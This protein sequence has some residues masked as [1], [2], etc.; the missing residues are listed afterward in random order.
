MTIVLASKFWKT[1]VG[2]IFPSTSEKQLEQKNK[3]VTRK[4]NSYIT[5]LVLCFIFQDHVNSL[6]DILLFPVHSSECFIEKDM[7]A[8]ITFLNIL[9][10]FKESWIILTNN[11]YKSCYK[12]HF[13]LSIC[14]YISIHCICLSV[15]HVMP[16]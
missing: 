15:S 7:F 6:Q 16:K 9:L 8:K 13:Y 1:C 12:L 3:T 11:H 4:I 2:W 10:I 14:I 5:Y